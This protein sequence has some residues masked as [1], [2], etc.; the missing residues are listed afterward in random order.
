MRVKLKQCMKFTMP[1]E[2]DLAGVKINDIKM[3]LPNPKI[4]ELKVGTHFI[5]LSTPRFSKPQCSSS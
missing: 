4:L 2:P 3:I 5:Y 1:N